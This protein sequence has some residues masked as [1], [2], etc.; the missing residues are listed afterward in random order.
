MDIQVVQGVMK[1]RCGTGAPAIAL[2]GLRSTSPEFQAKS[3][4]GSKDNSQSDPLSLRL[5]F[6]GN[7]H[8]PR[9]SAA[10]FWLSKRDRARSSTGYFAR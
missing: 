1:L 2:L 7:D 6:L 8:L 10:F 5:E 3:N 9:K 4:F